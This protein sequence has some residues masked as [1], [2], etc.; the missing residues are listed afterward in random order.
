MPSGKFV[1]P[2]FVRVCG[3]NV[4]VAGPVI[5]SEIVQEVMWMRS[6]YCLRMQIFLH[7]AVGRWFYHGLKV[8]PVDA[9]GSESIVVAAHRGDRVSV[10]RPRFLCREVLEE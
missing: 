1:E 4:A 6:T 2:D 5:V 8:D 3:T 10:D 7:D 9:D